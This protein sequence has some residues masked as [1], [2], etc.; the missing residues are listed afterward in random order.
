M[1]LAI[2]PDTI[3]SKRATTIRREARR[4]G[5]R[6]RPFPASIILDKPETNGE[7]APDLDPKKAKAF[8]G[9]VVSE[10]ESALRRVFEGWSEIRR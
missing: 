4:P 5:V 3:D 8:Y 10:I 9:A 2:A 1:V 7:G 6:A